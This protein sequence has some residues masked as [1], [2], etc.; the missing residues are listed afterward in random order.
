MQEF[1]QEQE[2]LDVCATHLEQ[3]ESLAHQRVTSDPKDQSPTKTYQECQERH[4]KLCVEVDDLYKRLKEWPS[5]W[6]VYQDR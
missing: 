3:L 1:F 5:Q 2:L 6:K 4:D